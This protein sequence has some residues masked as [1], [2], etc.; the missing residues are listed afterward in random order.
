MAFRSKIVTT[1]KSADGPPRGSHVLARLASDTRA[2]MLAIMAIA[3]IPLCGLVGGAVDISRLYLVKT[4]LQHACDAGALMGRKVMA[5]GTWAA[6]SNA[7]NT[8]ALQYFD[9]NFKDG[10]WGTI[11]RARSFTESSGVVTGTASADVPMTIMKVFKKPTKTLTVTCDAE[12]QLPN[13]DVMFVLD[14]TGSMGN[15]LSGETVDKIDNLKKGVKCFYEILMKTDTTASCGSTPTGGVSSAIQIRMGFMPFST[16][17]N[18]GKLL[19]TSYFATTWPYQTRKTSFTT[20]YYVVNTET[21][22]TTYETYGGGSTSNGAASG[23]TAINRSNCKDYGDNDPFDNP[24]FRPNPEGTP[25]NSGTQPSQTTLTEYSRYSFNGST[26]QNNWS[27]NNSYICVRKKVVTVTSWTTK[28]AFTNWSYDKYN[29]NV[30]NYVAGDSVT[31]ATGYSGYIDSSTANLDP[32]AL[33]QAPGATNLTTQSTSWDGCIEE[34]STVSQSSYDPIP[35]NAKDLDIDLIPSSGTANTLWGPTWPELHRSRRASGGGYSYAARNDVTNNWGN[36]SSYACP[37]EAKKLQAWPTASTFETYVDSLQPSGNTY[38][39]IGLLWGARFISPT[40]I[41][42]S[43]NA[44]TSSGGEIQRHIIFMTDGEVCTGTM[45]YQAYGVAWF[46]R[47]TTGAASAPTDGCSTDTDGNAG[48][49]LTAQVI[50]R[51]T[52]ICTAVK[53]KNITLWVIYYGS[54]SADDATRMS[55][56][57]TPGKYYA[58]NTNTSLLTIFSSIATQ[59]SQLRLT[60]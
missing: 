34:R 55:A 36:D 32:I 11:N 57:A 42:A 31:I 38:H 14:T 51:Y 16:N 37:T 25:L 12:M 4:R 13:T 28:Y 15:P 60:S 7:A 56:C 22:T 59:I 19:P 8:A 18:V 49:T 30:S 1:G 2:N 9:G 27:S 50:A 45:N 52:A 23:G 53:N 44:T 17:V 3:I 43:E 20:P 47:R 58:A 29:I 54:P 46:D 10:A 24:T 39:D 33:A 6:N 48:G 40:G 26:N 5:G 35:S 21:S 41:F